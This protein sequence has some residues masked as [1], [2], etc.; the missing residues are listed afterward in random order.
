MQEHT[1]H[2]LIISD[3]HLGSAGSSATKIHTL[4]EHMRF[5]RLL[6]LGDLFDHANIKRLKKEDWQFLSQLAGIADNDIE[7]VWIKGNHDREFPHTLSQLQRVNITEE[8]VWNDGGKK[9][10]AIHGDQFDKN[11]R[12]KRANNMLAHAFSLTLSFLGLKNKLVMSTVGSF[13]AWLIGLSDSVALEAFEY[14]IKHD[15][16]YIMCGHTH[17]P[18]IKTHV[19]NQ[20]ELKYLNTGSWTQFGPT[21]ITIDKDGPKLHSFRIKK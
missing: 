19:H 5:K 14:G 3:L 21:Y 8:Y 18:V 6:I 11:I 12:E 16:D 17:I 1:T 2:T 9:Y 15:A 20:K 7:V 13:Y 10:I 4:L